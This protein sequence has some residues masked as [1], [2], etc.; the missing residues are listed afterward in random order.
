MLINRAEC[1]L[2]KRKTAMLVDRA[3]INASSRDGSR[4]GVGDRIEQPSPV[5]AQTTYAC[6]VPMPCQWA[7]RGV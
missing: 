2:S 7:V 5:P 1:E 6:L 3:I 4:S